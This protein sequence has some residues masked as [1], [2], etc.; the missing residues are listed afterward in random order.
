MVEIRT[1]L[2]KIRIGA[3]NGKLKSLDKNGYLL[4][5][6]ILKGYDTRRVILG[7]MSLS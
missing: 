4:E 7:I 1:T 2:V 5:P 3:Q 6:S